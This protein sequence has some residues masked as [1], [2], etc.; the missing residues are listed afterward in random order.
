MSKKIVSEIKG[1]EGSVTIADPLLLPQSL[2]LRKAQKEVSGFFTKKKGE[3]VLKEDVVIEEY[4]LVKLPSL[5]GCIEKW[6]IE[7]KTQPTA[8]TFPIAGTDIDM[9]NAISFTTWLS[10][11]IMAL[12]NSDEDDDPNS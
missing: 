4:L 9:A 3:F 2:A 7:G 10:S 5:F 8:E 6:N 1:W 11:E 12:Y